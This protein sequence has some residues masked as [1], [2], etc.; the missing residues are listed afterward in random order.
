MPH[1][2]P[3]RL[4]DRRTTRF[5]LPIPRLRP[6]PRLPRPRRPLASPPAAHRLP[7]RRTR[8]RERRARRARTTTGATA[9]T[10]SPRRP[11]LAPM[12]M[13][14]TRRCGEA[15]LR[16]FHDSAPFVS[17]SFFPAGLAHLTPAPSQPPSDRRFPRRSPPRRTRRASPPPAAS[18]RSSPSKTRRRAHPSS[19]QH[20]FRRPCSPRV[21]AWPTIF[22]S[23]SRAT[24]CVRRMTSLSLSPSPRAPRRYGTIPVLIQP[25]YAG[26][27]LP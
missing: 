17:H 1:P 14:M 24:F 7:R 10:T 8:R 2:L 27:S 5:L 26:L 9:T 23:V 22:L 3:N 20:S 21:T 11:P 15:R 12:T 6:P 13:T 18:R 4:A 25:P 19:L 16:F